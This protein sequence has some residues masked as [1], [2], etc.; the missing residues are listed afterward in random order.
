MMRSQNITSAIAALLTILFV[1]TWGCSHRL[2]EKIPPLESK[3]E[4][5]RSHGAQWCAPKE[6]S[7]AEAYLDFA[8]T[9]IARKNIA[10]AQ[11]FLNY[12]DGYA[13]TSLEKTANCKN[14]LDGDGV[15]DL[16][17]GDPYRAEDY[18]GWQDTDGIPDGDNDGDGF[19][20][21]EDACPDSAEDFD[22]HEDKDGCPDLDNDVDGIPDGVDK[23]KYQPED[24]DGWLDED[25]CPDLD[26][27]MDGFPDVEDNCPDAAETKNGFLDDDGCPDI[28]PKIFKIILTPE[29]KF[30]GRSTRLYN[31]YKKA[32]AEFAGQLIANPE[33]SLRIEAHLEM[34]SNPAGDKLITQKQAEVVAQT[35]IGAGIESER[36]IPIGFGGER[37]LEDVK[38]RGNRRIMLIVFQTQ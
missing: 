19:L 20:D 22:G 4:K 3:L 23:C 30:S 21:G 24:I 35:L 32:L 38:G 6:Y 25:G 27:D 36:L 33:L 5:A 10:D 16:L 14:D 18:D 15:V 31:K 1:F 29:I 7:A 37:P 2:D 12:A 13:N 28:Q 26:N 11:T 34:G 9:E 17:D 8:K